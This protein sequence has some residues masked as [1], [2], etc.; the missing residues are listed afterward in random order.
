MKNIPLSPFSYKETEA[1]RGNLL[2]GS[3]AG[4]ESD[5]LTPSSFHLPLGGH[6]VGVPGWPRGCVLDPE[7]QSGAEASSRCFQSLQP[8]AVAEPKFWF[9]FSK[10]GQRRLLGR[11]CVIMKCKTVCKVSSTAPGT[12]WRFSNRTISSVLS[13]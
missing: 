8:R 7:R 6:R 5:Q 10:A 2:V 1:Q 13:M 3:R 12:Q 11:V 9:L 4:L